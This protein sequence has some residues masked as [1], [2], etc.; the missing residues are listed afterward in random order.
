MNSIRSTQSKNILDYKVV[1]F[2]LD[3]TLY[4]QNS[5]RVKMAVRMA[6]YYL[7]H[8]FRIREFFIVKKFREV[9]EAWDDIYHSLSGDKDWDRLYESMLNEKASG[10]LNKMQYSYVAKKMKVDY[11]K[12]EFAINKWIY[13]NP[14][15]VVYETRD[16]Q[17][18]EYIEYLR[19]SGIKV[20]ILSDYPTK[21]K[22]N[23]LKLKV[24]GEYS[25]LDSSINELKPSPMGLQ[26]IMKDFGVSESDILMVGDRY[27]KDGMAAIHAACEYVI[28]PKSKNKRNYKCIFEPLSVNH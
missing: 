23:A 28:L 12:V 14:L 8:P 3:G 17:L 10:D 6:K 16:T 19:K 5:L 13:E 20:V 25:A 27:S 26:V 9:R 11:K 4:F 1:V 22:L 21:D 15:D 24:D 2:D 7:C 18:L